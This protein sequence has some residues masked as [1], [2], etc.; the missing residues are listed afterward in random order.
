MGVVIARPALPPGPYLVVG[1]ARSGV[2]AALALRE[3]GAEVA[4]TD[5]GRVPEEAIERLRAAGV[6]T[7]VGSDGLSLLDRAR[8][9]VKS[10][11]VPRQAAVIAAARERGI[12]VLGEFELG[13]RMLPDQEFIAVTGSNGK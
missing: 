5:V 12:E 9:V 1:L 7:Q 11:G 10:P 6:E 4:G 8:S 13:W 2:A 3:R